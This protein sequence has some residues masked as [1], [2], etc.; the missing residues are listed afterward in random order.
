M[1]DDTLIFKNIVT[2]HKRSIEFTEGRIERVKWIKDNCVGRYEEIFG[3]DYY[4]EFKED[5]FMFKMTWG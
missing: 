3:K 4:F 2:I 1:M 5:A